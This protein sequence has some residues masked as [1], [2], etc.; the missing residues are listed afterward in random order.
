MSLRLKDWQVVNV[1]NGTGFIV[2]GKGRFQVNYQ[3]EVLMGEATRCGQRLQ[4]Q[5]RFHVVRVPDEYALP[6]G[7]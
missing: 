3:G 6:R 7:G 5:R 2:T 4:P 1:G